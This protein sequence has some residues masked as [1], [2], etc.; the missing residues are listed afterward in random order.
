MQSLCTKTNMYCASVCIAA[1]PAAES[2]WRCDGDDAEATGDDEA[3]DAAYIRYIGL[4][5]HLCTRMEV[6]EFARSSRTHST[7]SYCNF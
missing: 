2:G 7:Y 5:P 3:D 4:E 1:L 6:A